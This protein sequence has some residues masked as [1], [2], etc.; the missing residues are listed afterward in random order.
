MPGSA[1]G[2]AGL[3]ELEGDGPA[4]ATE[5]VLERDLD[6]RLDVAA[7]VGAEARAEV[8][9]IS[10]IDVAEAAARAS[11]AQ[12]SEDRPE[13]VGE[14]LA[15][16]SEVDLCALERPARPGTSLGISLPLATSG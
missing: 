2:G 6:A 11:A 5:R 14:A 3:V 15:A 1:A 4:D 16:A 9:E 10:Q 12:V 13:K 8:A 7:L